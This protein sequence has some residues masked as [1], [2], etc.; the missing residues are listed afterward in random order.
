[1]PQLP[2]PRELVMSHRPLVYALIGL[3]IASRLVPH[4]PNFVF[5]GAL[6][7][8]AGCHFRGIQAWLAPLL[9]LGISDLIGHFAGLRG[10]GFYHP[11]V[12][13]AVYT[14]VAASGWIGKCLRQRQTFT[15][16]VGGSL[17]CSTLFFLL[18][19]FAVW[20]SGSYPPGLAGLVGCYSAAIP[21]YQHTLAGDLFYTA[22]T[23]GSLA[24][25]KAWQG[26]GAGIPSRQRLA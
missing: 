24:A 23:F 1:M 22:L 18:S 3:A 12:M 9:A 6:G 26:L 21:F 25:W 11:G 13:L 16:V 5:I 10:M 8:F 4:P 7:L 19:N 15:R 2:L 14:A 20:L 17:A